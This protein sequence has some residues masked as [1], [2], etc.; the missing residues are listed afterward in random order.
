MCVCYSI[1]EFF[2][3]LN[4][5]FIQASELSLVFSLPIVGGE[6]ALMRS[7]LMQTASFRI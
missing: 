3:S 4:G 6:K 2:F 7:E 1:K 5:C